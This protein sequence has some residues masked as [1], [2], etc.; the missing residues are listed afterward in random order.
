[1]GGIGSGRRNQV[2]KNTTEDSRP[3]DMRK[4]N[5]SGLLQPGQSFGWQWTVCGRPVSDIR[6]HVKTDHVVLA[7]KYR[8]HREAEWEDISQS[9]YID[10]TACHLGG[11]RCWWLCPTCGRRVAVLY[12]PGRHYACRHCFR[13]TYASQRETADD[14]AARRADRIRRLLGWQI[15]ILNPRGS[16]PKGMHWRTFVQLTARHAAYV[17][18]SMAG[19]AERIGLINQPVKSLGLDPFDDLS[20]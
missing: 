2:G 13:L 11:T 17:G 6:I 14:R 1:M 8:K 3:L 9:I 10:R 15:G 20:G 16:K 18:V 7:Y 5:R 4:L 19:M 12:G